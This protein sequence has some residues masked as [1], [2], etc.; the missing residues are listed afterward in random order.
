MIVFQ[1]KIYVILPGSEQVH[2]YIQ[3]DDI[4]VKNGLL[5]WITRFEKVQLPKPAV[6]NNGKKDQQIYDLQQKIYELK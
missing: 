2:K 6:E 5:V 3:C 4:L 1:K